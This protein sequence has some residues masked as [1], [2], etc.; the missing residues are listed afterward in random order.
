MKIEIHATGGATVSDAHEGKQNPDG[1][2]ATKTW[3]VNDDQLGKHFRGI[4]H[5]DHNW[6]SMPKG[7]KSAARDK[8][9]EYQKQKNS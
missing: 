7:D 1:T 3:H 4:E 5:P 6:R 2:P 9:N 8:A